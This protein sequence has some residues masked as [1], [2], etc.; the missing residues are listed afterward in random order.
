MPLAFFSL[1][2]EQMAFKTLV[3]FHLAAAGDSESFRCSSVGFDFW[4]CSSLE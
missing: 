4:H 1:A 2:R 3:P